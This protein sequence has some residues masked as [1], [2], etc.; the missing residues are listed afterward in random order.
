MKAGKQYPFCQIKQ[1]FIDREVCNWTLESVV[2]IVREIW[3]KA[4]MKGSIC[5]WYFFVGESL[6]EFNIVAELVP[7]SHGSSWILRI[8]NK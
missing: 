3:P 2:A 5:R 8:K 6:T 7:A 4:N 1:N